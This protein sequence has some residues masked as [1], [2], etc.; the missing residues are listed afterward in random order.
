MQKEIILGAGCFWGVQAAFDLMKGVTNT[1]V[2]YSGGTVEN[3]SYELIC[4]KMT[5]HI[6]VVKIT[7]DSS[8]LDIHN[9]MMLFMAIHNPTQIDGQANDIGPQYLSSIFYS[10]DEEKAI[11][12][13]EISTYKNQYDSPIVTKILPLE[14]FYSAEDYHQNYLVKNPGGYCHI[15]LPKV[16]EFLDSKGLGLK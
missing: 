6:E 11:F 5:G 2:G 3:P 15:S 8:L 10:G 13:Q 9:I 12:E 1:E 16:K 7:Y 14:K 4:S